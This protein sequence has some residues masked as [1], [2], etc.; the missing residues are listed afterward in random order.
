MFAL[1]GNNVEAMGLFFVKSYLMIRKD[2]VN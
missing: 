1:M 2:S